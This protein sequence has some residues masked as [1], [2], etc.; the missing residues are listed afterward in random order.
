MLTYHPVFKENLLLFVSSST[1]RAYL[2]VNINV[3]VRPVV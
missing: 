1:V 3:I 2:Y